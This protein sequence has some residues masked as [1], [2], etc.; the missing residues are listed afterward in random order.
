MEV[1]VA[2]F[3]LGAFGAALLTALQT[4][5]RATQTLDQ[6]VTASN[7]AAAYLEEIRDTP[8]ANSYPWVGTSIPKPAGYTVTVNIQ[9]STDGVTFHACQGTEHFQRI[10]VIVMQDGRTILSLCTYRS[11]R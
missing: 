7:L 5:A 4:N 11:E 6:K 8:Y 10:N 9:C 1:L 2:L 3:I